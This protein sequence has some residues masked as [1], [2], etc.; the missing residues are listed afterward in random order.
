MTTLALTRTHFRFL[1]LENLRVP[2]A[3]GSAAI[4]PALSLLFFVVPFGFGDDVAAATSAVIQ[5]AV[6]GVLSSFLFTFGVGV[7][8]DREKAWDPYVR[9]LP[10]AATPRIVGRLL[11]GFV[12]A[13]IAIV[14]VT[15]VGAALTSASVTPLRFLAG[16]VAMLVA[17]LP[18]LLGGL[19][20][21]YSMPV[22]AALPVTQLIFFPLA[23]GG[24]LF[25]PPQLFPDWLQTISEL[26]PSRGARDVVIWAVQGITPSVLTIVSF[27]VWIVATAAIAGWAYRRDEGRRFR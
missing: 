8:D 11:T 1:L 10:A 2:I 12:F 15:I 17:G 26:L 25:L 14:P 22:K 7:A 19:A 3:V 27:A 4:F 13:L 24:G 23:F 18:F 5:L 6:F 20:V 9:T 21:G 16:L